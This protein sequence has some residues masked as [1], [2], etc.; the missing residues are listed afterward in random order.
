MGSLCT[1]IEETNTYLKLEDINTG[2]VE[3]QI[4]YVQ[5]SMTNIFNIKKPSEEVM[6]AAAIKYPQ[7]I[8]CMEFPE[9]IQ[10]LIM[11][12]DGTKI[13]YIDSPSEAVQMRAIMCTKNAFLFIQYPSKNMIMY[14][15]SLY[16][17]LLEFV[18]EQDKSLQLAAL[19]SGGLTIYRYIK[20]P[21][22]LV[23]KKYDQM[24]QRALVKK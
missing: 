9:R 17:D 13:R 24:V 6:A 10:F 11:K 5:K 15:I 19:M 18:E 1:K 3:Q 4:S 12:I 8:I 22:E 2:T 23:K 14:A 20:N 21:S 16:P 7:L